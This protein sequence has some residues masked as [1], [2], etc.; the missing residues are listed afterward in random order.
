[1][2]RPIP[3]NSIKVRLCVEFL[4]GVIFY[5]LVILTLS[6]QR[7][8][9]VAGFVIVI[10]LFISLSEGVFLF[11]K[12][13]SKRYPWH[14]KTNKRVVALFMF[15]FFWGGVVSLIIRQFQKFYYSTDHLTRH[16][17][18][19]VLSLGVLFISIY[20]ILLIAFNYH[21]SLSF[22]VYENEKLKQEKLKLDYFALQEQV[23]PHFL[24]NNLSTLIAI[25]QSDKDLA[26][27]FAQNFSD[28]YRYVLQSKDVYAV[29]VKDEVE[30]IKSCFAL[31]QERLGKGLII[32]IDIPVEYH[33]GYIPPLS[34]QILVE[35]AIK[36]NSATIKKPLHISIL[37]R[38][39]HLMVVNNLNPRNSTYSTNTGLENLKKRYSLLTNDVPRVQKTENEFSVELPLINKAN[40]DASINS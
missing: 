30:F 1:M 33:T 35:N 4:L 38:N 23:N 24:F 14:I 9:V 17:H 19:L 29:R 5:S 27:R 22:F 13:I 36:H 2:N 40:V 21:E 7:K 12:S 20:V 32:D 10:T 34:L 31:H 39:N 25:I 16:D 37:G 18:L 28:V 26:V 11:N 3:F 6:P 15:I 8:P